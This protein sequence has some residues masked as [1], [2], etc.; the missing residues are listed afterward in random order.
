MRLTLVNRLV[1][2]ITLMIVISC[3]LFALVKSA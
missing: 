2:L 1:Y 3:I